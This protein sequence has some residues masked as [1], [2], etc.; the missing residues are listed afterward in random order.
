MAQ[1]NFS[2]PLRISAIADITLFLLVLH[3]AGLLSFHL[4]AAARNSNSKRIDDGGI[5][6]PA[7]LSGSARHIVATRNLP[8]TLRCPII[9]TSE[10]VRILD[11]W[12]MKDG[13]KLDAYPITNSGQQQQTNSQQSQPL[14]Q[15]STQAHYH[16]PSSPSSSSSSSSSSTSSTS[17]R[18]VIT[19][20]GDLHFEKINHKV[21][22]SGQRH[23]NYSDEGD[24]RCVVKSPL[25]VV[26]SSVISVSV[27]Q[28][29]DTKSTQEVK[30]KSGEPTLLECQ[31]AS[32]SSYHSSSDLRFTWFRGDNVTITQELDVRYNILSSGTL[33][34]S[35]VNSSDAGTYRC[36]SWDEASKHERISF[37]SLVILPGHDNV[38]SEP[39]KILSTPTFTEGKTVLILEEEES[40]T[41]D[42]VAS[43]IPLPMINWVMTI[44]NDNGT[45]SVQV[46]HGRYFRNSINITS[47]LLVRGSSDVNFTCIA[48]NGLG[49]VSRTIQVFQLPALQREPVSYQYPPAKT[50]RFE[51]KVNPIFSLIWYK[52]G[53]VLEAGKGRVKVKGNEL[54]VSNTIRNDSGFYQCEVIADDRV[55]AVGTARLLVNNSR[56]APD[57]PTNVECIENHPTALTVS[58]K[59]PSNF[60]DIHA[61]SVHYMPFR[62]AETQRVVSKE[63]STVEISSL[64]PHTNYSIYVRSYSTKSASVQS[65]LVVCETTEDVPLNKP[66]QMKMER[67]GPP[68]QVRIYWKRLTNKEARGK[69]ILYKLQWRSVDGEFSNVRYID[70]ESEEFLI[71]DLDPDQ[72]YELRLIP[73]TSMGWPARKDSMEW[74]RVNASIFANRNSTNNNESHSIIFDEYFAAPSMHLTVLNST[75]ALVNWS[76]P[77]RPKEISVKGFRITYSTKSERVKDVVFFGPITVY[78]DNAREHL[79]TNLVS[80]ATYEFYLQTWGTGWE[81]SVASKFIRTF[82]DSD[83]EQWLNSG[84]G[85]LTTVS[86]LQVHPISSTEVRLKWD[87]AMINNTDG[88]FY[89]VKYNQV[90]TSE[91]HTLSSTRESVEIIGLTPYTSYEFVVQLALK[92]GRFGPYSQ[93]IES[94][95]LPGIPGVPINLH[96]RVLNQ[97][98]VE[99]EWKPPSPPNGII[100]KYWVEFKLNK[101]NNTAPNSQNSTSGGSA[102]AI[103]TSTVTTTTTAAVTNG[104]WAVKPTSNTSIFLNELQINEYYAVRVKAETRAG[105]G[106]PSDIVM[107]RI[108]TMRPAPPVI[109]ESLPQDEP[110]TGQNPL[111]NDQQRLGIIIGLAL[112]AVFV[113]LCV[114]IILCRNRFFPLISR[115]PLGTMYVNGNGHPPRAMRSLE[116]INCVEMKVL[117]GLTSVDGHLDTK[118]GH[119]VANGNVPSATDPLLVHISRNASNRHDNHDDE[120][121]PNCVH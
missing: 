108:L 79:F 63:V 90:D 23:R 76:E 28:S 15:T 17:P 52:D 3:A 115:P 56:D 38:S 100:T 7:S 78:N 37:V 1:R 71:T 25:G 98:I 44:N 92:D 4:T 94:R 66:P 9:I 84:E 54:V 119:P 6:V 99:V 40:T 110:T 62:G 64:I 73:S 36:V 70:G 27:A 65:T 121:I 13:V 26:L 60:K 109:V 111:S 97:T 53:Q 32:F 5:K 57:A 69:I 58:W 106:E 77:P 75:S 10:D 89:I 20:E 45:L 48:D 113:S 34:I 39:P 96:W 42:C 114:T 87:Q 112:S 61:F 80:G 120:T 67:F 16:P 21:I 47:D 30:T 12:W 85:M 14:I 8:L 107:V 50:V 11:L 74:T 19:K 103:T 51:C 68:S 86:G 101:V 59:Q 116:S 49:P 91:I 33:A 105:T 46:T 104:S 118:G 88:H 31:I 18:I 29:A 95:T 82:T 72:D 83:D 55:Y 43:G 2:S 24:Y 93:K 102:T 22:T 117:V 41:L 81:S 35:R